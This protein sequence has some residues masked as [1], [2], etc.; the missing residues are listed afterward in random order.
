MKRRAKTDRSK[1]RR[2]AGYRRSLGLESLEQRRVLTVTADVVGTTLIIEGDADDHV[3]RL[4]ID[5]NELVVTPIPDLGALA[6]QATARG[7]FNG[8]SAVDIVDYTVWRDTLGST[9][10]LRADANDDGVVDEMDRDVWVTNFGTPPPLNPSEL[11]ES[12]AGITRIVVDLG[13]GDDQLIFAGTSEFDLPMLTGN[14]EVTLEVESSVEQTDLHQDIIA[15]DPAAMAVTGGDVVIDSPVLL[16]K[17]AALTAN[18]VTFGSTIDSADNNDAATSDFGL[19]VTLGG[20]LRFDGAVGTA[21]TLLDGT[22]D[23]DGLRFLETADLN[24]ND[25]VD[26]IV[27]GGGLPDTIV[28]TGDQ[29][30]AGPVVLAD[31]TSITSSNGSVEFANT[32]TG[33][34]DLAVLFFETLTFDAEVRIQG[35]LAIDDYETGL[36]GDRQ[37]GQVKLPPAVAITIGNG[38]IQ[39]EGAGGSQVYNAP[40]LLRSDT[41][42]DSTASTITFNGP[43]DSLNDGNE[44]TAA[45]GMT[46]RGAS[47]VFLGGEIGGGNQPVTGMQSDPDGVRA[48]E[49]GSALSPVVFDVTNAGLDGELAAITTTEAQ[50]YERPVILRQDTLLKSTDDGISFFASVDAENDNLDGASLHG[51]TVEVADFLSVNAQIGGDNFDMLG[52]ESDPDGLEFFTVRDAS[53]GQLELNVPAPLIAVQTTID[54]TYDVAVLLLEDTILR[55]TAGSILF[56]SFVD[57]AENGVAGTSDR[58]LEVQFAETVEVNAEVGGD[59]QDALDMPSDAD[60]LQFFTT[61]EITPGEGQAKLNVT[62]AAVDGE[63]VAIETTGDQDFNTA[64]LLMQDTLLRSTEG[65]IIFDG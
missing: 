34:H 46:V 44:G 59:N 42:F 16:T 17:S 24:A 49:F 60:G 56:N 43:V 8:D 7:D 38:G 41:S 9:T 54:Q 63:L 55:S 40:L 39:T 53:P 32:V 33:P 2:A 64:T 19:T 27:L 21:P 52:I 4:S 6:Q 12:L 28:T 30:Y 11:T 18:N 26:E 25:P 48:V 37:A 20:S 65:S 3:V 50:R 14:T 47:G 5:S 29:T 23:E 61:N 15:V 51:L 10:D 35:A 57:S 45:Y 62:D 1:P 36:P 58:G 22:A 13:G 31:D